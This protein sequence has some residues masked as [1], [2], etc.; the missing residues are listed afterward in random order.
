MMIWGIHKIMY[1]RSISLTDTLLRSFSIHQGI[2]SVPVSIHIPGTLSLPIVESGKIHGVWIISNTSANHVQQSAV[3]GESGNIIIYAHNTYA[4][5]G[6]LQTVK[7]GDRIQIRT[8]DTVMHQYTVTL[9]H[10]VDVDNTFSLQPTQSEVL[11][12]YTCS[13]FLDSK[14]LIVRAVPQGISL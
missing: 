3:P 13:G 11:T 12:L 6:P 2:H 14:R 8:K 5:F 9:V 1:A 4:L 10:E 7:I